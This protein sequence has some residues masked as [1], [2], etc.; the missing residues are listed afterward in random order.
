MSRKTIAVLATLDTKG[1]E[2]EFLREQIGKHGQRALIVDVG[3]MGAPAAKADVTRAEVAE[4][5]GTPLA[6]LLQNPDREIAA[7]LMAE[8]ATKIVSR[9]AAEKKI[10]GVLGLGGTQGTTLCTQVMRALPYGFPKVMVSTMASGNVAPW[11]DIRDITMMFSVA[12]IMG[13]NPVT[14]KILANAAGA[15]CGMASTDVEMETGDTN[16]VAVTTV[17]I[18]TQGAMKAV[19]VLEAAGLHTI[20]FHAIGAGGRAME[21]MMKEGIIAAVL[22]YSTIEVSNEM[23]HALLAGG[24][25]RCTTAGKLGIPQVIAPGAIEVLVFNEPE[26]VPPP[27]NTRTLIR[28]SPKITDV[29]LNAAEMAN[30]GKELAR[31]LSFTKDRAVFMIPTAGYDSYAVKGKGFYDPEADAAFVRELTANL[32]SCIEVVK[33]D[34]HIEDPA[35]AVE[36]AKT[37]LTLIDAKK[38]AGAK[39]R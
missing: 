35:F 29:R 6:R 21:Q 22:D 14:R 27:F 2:A 7:P 11:V 12:D 31:R 25:E 36:A 30:V 8:G 10:H 17:G 9:L 16:L 26:T 37:L 1:K 4:A 24:P 3:V 15:A 28:H 34:T 39:G 38:R 18:T 23:Y 33:R 13:L 19:E 20:V 5:G 32:P